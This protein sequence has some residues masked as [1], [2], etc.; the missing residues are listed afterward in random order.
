MKFSE[1]IGNGPMNKQLNFVGDPGHRLDT[2]ILYR[3]RHNWEIRK[4]VRPTKRHKS[5]GHTES[6]DGGTGKM[7]LGGG[8]HCPSASIVQIELTLKRARPT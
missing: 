2:G 7:C 6:P 4:V 8:M 1:K 3:I 5:A